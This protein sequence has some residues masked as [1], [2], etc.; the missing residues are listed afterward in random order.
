MA[1][2]LLHADDTPIRVL[3]RSQ[4]NKGLGKGVKKGR[5][6]AYIRD[7]RPWAGTAP[8][9]GECPTFCVSV[10]WAMLPERSKD[11]ADFERTSG[12]V[13]EGLQAA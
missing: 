7:Q 12:R 10:I 2:D 11:D 9:G 1:S 4:R 5:I 6:W 8:P 13:A 3:D